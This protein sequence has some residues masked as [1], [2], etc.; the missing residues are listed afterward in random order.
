MLMLKTRSTPPVKVNA[1]LLPAATGS[2]RTNHG[3]NAWSRPDS[4]ITSQ[5]QDG[6]TQD[7]AVRNRYAKTSAT[8]NTKNV[9]G[10]SS[11][12]ID[13]ED[14]RLNGGTRSLM[15]RLLGLN[16]RRISN[17]DQLK[18]DMVKAVS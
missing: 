10:C 17:K 14:A 4:A 7:L 2:H 3:G 11:L 5:P 16:L 9:V 13:P 6:P 1:T 15:R 18:L 12:V 8:V